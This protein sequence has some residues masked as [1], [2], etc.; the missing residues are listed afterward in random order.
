M[1]KKKKK[2]ED[3]AWLWMSRPF[4]PGITSIPNRL[5]LPLP[6]RGKVSD[7]SR[8]TDWDEAF[9]Y[10]TFTGPTEFMAAKSGIQAAGAS[11]LGFYG[12]SLLTALRWELALDFAVF[13]AVLTVFDPANK[14]KGGLDESTSWEEGDPVP[15][16][17]GNFLHP[18]SGYSNR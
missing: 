16:S 18:R 17:T 13:G 7:Q 3:D 14:W 1:G 12:G 9:I 15:F 4:L 5:P 8:T 11:R 10:Y 6:D 2:I